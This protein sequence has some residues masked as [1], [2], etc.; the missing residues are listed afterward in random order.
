MDKESPYVTLADGTEFP[1]DFF[2]YAESVGWQYIDIPDI[3]LA[4]AASVFSDSEKTSRIVFK[5]SSDTVVRE[6]FTVCVGVTITEGICRITMRRPY[7]QPEDTQAL[8]EAKA[9]AAEYKAALEL[10]GITTE[11]VTE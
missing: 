5:N 4:D 8:E 11:E 3:T 7:A 10:L 9:E 1:C 2:G 6:G